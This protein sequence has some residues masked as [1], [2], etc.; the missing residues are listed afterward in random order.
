MAF[1]DD[2]NFAYFQLLLFSK[3][4]LNIAITS[5]HYFFNS[6]CDGLRF[7]QLNIS[8]N[9]SRYWF[10][11][12]GNFF[13]VFTANYCEGLIMALLRCKI[14][15]LSTASL[16]RKLLANSRMFYHHIQHSLECNVLCEFCRWIS[17]LP[18]TPIFKTMQ[19]ASTFFNQR[20][21]NVVS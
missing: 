5:F 12:N 14:K 9:T 8:N 15:L 17:K 19:H 20:F 6:F 1:W 16:K 2:N 11:Q 13:S 18:S 21:H 3:L 10:C 4:F 7:C